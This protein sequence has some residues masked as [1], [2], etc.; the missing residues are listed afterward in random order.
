MN[1]YS[2]FYWLT[3]A[4]NARYFFGIFAGIFTAFSVISTIAFIFWCDDDDVRDSAKK[5]IWWSYPFMI[6]FWGF[7]IFTPSK[8]DSLLII[9]GGGTMNFLTSDSTAKQIPHE[10]TNFV[11]TE[12]K[13][14][15]KSAEIEIA[16]DDY[17]KNILKEAEG[18]TGK[19]LIEAMKDS[20]FAK[21]ILEE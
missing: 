7:L 5:W 11:V 1:Y 16:T 10:L 3:V 13:S 4:D 17:K 15:A 12:L 20:T 9:A 18:M 19:E 8:K 21:I 6:L 14:M 2:V